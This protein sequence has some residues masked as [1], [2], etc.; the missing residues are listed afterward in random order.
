MPEQLTL[1]NNKKDEK[2]VTYCTVRFTVGWL[3]GSIGFTEQAKATLADTRNLDKKVI[4]GSYAILGASRDLLIKEGAALKRLLTIIRD[5]FT[6]PEYTLRSA[7]TA[8]EVEKPHKL[9]GSYLIESCR[10]E[11]FLEK[12]NQAREQYLLWGKRVAQSENYNRIREADK[13]NLGKDWEVVECRYPSAEALAES[14]SCDLPKIEPFDASFTLA[15]VAPETAKKLTEQ[16]RR[17]LEASVDGAIIDFVSE[18][19]SMVE[20]IAKN[21]GRRIRINPSDEDKKE[22][23]HAEV[24]SIVTHDDSKDVPEGKLL[25]T[26][27]PVKGNK[28]SGSVKTFV[29]TEDEYSKLHPYETDE[30]RQ[31]TKSAFENIKWLA[32]KINTIKSMLQNDEHASDLSDLVDEVESTMNKFGKDSDN[33][34]KSLRNSNYSREAAKTTFTKLASK[35]RD[36]EMKICESK[37]QRRKIVR[38]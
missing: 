12:F 17:R 29:V 38:R 28:N 37:A 9:K 26:V 5:E 31:L 11:E 18:F 1:F 8:N 10:V 6:I 30:Y 13:Q 16:A 23:K 3:P 15:D 27:Q 24:T 22:L 21:C 20:V 19:K 36:T 35:I 4:R 2:T 25:I 33:I 34:V 7:A 14:I 32:A